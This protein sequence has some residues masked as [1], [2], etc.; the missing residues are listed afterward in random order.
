MPFKIRKLP[1]KELYRVYNADTGDVLAKGTT[2][3]K[4]EAQLRL[5]NS[6]Y[7]KELKKNKRN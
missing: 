6:I 5:L 7:E 1:N 4:A 2:K 3:K